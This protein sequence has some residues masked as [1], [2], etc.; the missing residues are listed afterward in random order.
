MRQHFSGM[1]HQN[2]QQVLLL[3]RQLHL[4]FA[5]LHNAANQVDGEV[6][7]PE[8][9]PFTLQLQL[10]PER[11]THSGQKLVH[12]ERLRNVIIGTQI[13]RLHLAGFVAAAGKHD[14]WNLF[15]ARADR[16]QQ[17]VSLNIGQAEIE[18]DQIRRLA[19]ELERRLAVTSLNDLIALRSQSH[20]QELAN[21]W[22][23]VDD[24][25]L[26]GGSRHATES[27]SRTLTEIGNLIV[28]NAPERSPRFAATIVPFSASTKPREMARP[29]PV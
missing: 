15:I 1:L 9:R 19:H 6:A 2:A 16:S 8:D 14:Y 26:H 4:F 23:V 11:R 29:K 24:K 18:N 10:M 12:P 3:G 21:R 27:S 7:D 25:H 13:E 22:F 17:L 5:D 20:S 28:N